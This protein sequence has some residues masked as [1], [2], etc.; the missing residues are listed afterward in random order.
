MARIVLI[1]GGCRSG[2]SDHAQQLAESLQGRRVFVATCPVTDDEMKQRIEQH[3]RQ[4]RG[5]GWETI[6]EQLDPGGTIRRCRDYD[7]VLVDC[8]TLWIN[9]LMFEAGKRGDSIDEQ[10][11]E[12]AAAELLEACNEHGG[13]IVFV[14]NEVGT[15][16]V[17]L[18][19]VSRRYR[20]LVGRLNQLMAAA[21]N[22]VTLLVCGIPLALK[23]DT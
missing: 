3:Q 14:S 16:I 13:T 15:G 4:R 9:N 23:T 18:D 7:V 19:A 11:I 1:T 20:D 8:L 17:P 6:E 2:K 5:R 22:E 12:N 10:Q 21:A